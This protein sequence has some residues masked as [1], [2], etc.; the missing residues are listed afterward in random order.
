MGTDITDWFF[1]ALRT[2]PN[3]GR[4]MMKIVIL[5]F[6]VLATINAAALQKAKAEDK[7]AAVKEEIAVIGDKKKA[8]FIYSDKKKAEIAVIGDKK[9][10]EFIY[11]D[12]KK[13]E[14]LFLLKHILGDEK[15][16]EFLYLLKHIL[17][18]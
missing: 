10:A 4:K 2:P 13:A 16:A 17:G 3:Y 6:A 8:E 1:S 15:K 5:L 7:P 14:F 18:D 9:K 12:K 11:G